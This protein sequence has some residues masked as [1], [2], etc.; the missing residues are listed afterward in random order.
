M[1]WVISSGMAS[2]W[3]MDLDLSASNV[4]GGSFAATD[5]SAGAAASPMLCCWWSISI[6]TVWRLPL[7]RLF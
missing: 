3:A 5:K 6:G 7:W 4:D 1:A 2:C